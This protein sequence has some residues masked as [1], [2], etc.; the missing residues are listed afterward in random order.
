MG[1]GKYGANL[2]GGVLSRVY[3]C[4]AGVV[5][6]S[7]ICELTELLNGGRIWIYIRPL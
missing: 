1:G 6:T 5:S 4:R 2:N 3:A 7:I